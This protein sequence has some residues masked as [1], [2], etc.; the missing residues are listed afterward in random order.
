MKR[1]NLSA[2][3]LNS[4]SS[5]LNLLITNAYLICLTNNKEYLEYL[6]T[7]ARSRIPRMQ[8]FFKNFNKL[9]KETRFSSSAKPPPTLNLLLRIRNA[10]SSTMS[11]ILEIKIKMKH[12]RILSRPS[13][14]LKAKKSR[15][16]GNQLEKI[17]RET[18]KI[19]FF[20]PNLN[21]K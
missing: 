9:L 21:N 15:L 2:R 4:A 12:P 18:T 5:I 7:L 8:T 10:R 20:L 17:I 19:N 11:I 13:Q 16:S 6:M 3:D 1:Q 14:S